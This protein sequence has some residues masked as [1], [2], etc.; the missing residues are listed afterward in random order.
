MNSSTARH[1]F[2]ILFCFSLI[3]AYAAAQDEGEPP[4][5]MEFTHIDQLKTAFNK[6]AGSERI[7]LLLSPT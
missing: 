6:D 5:A 1:F 3:G 7:V 4:S 2:A